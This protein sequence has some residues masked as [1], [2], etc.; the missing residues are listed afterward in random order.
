MMTDL[1]SP[2]GEVRFTLQVTRKETGK[3]EE[4]EMVGSTTLTEE[5]LKKELSSVNHPLDRGA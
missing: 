1:V 5:Q 4:Y 2:I 3:V